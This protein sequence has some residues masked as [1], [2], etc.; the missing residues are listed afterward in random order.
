MSA[1]KSFI[2]VWNVVGEL[3]RPKNITRGSKAPRWQTKA[4]FHFTLHLKEIIFSY[5][6][7]RKGSGFVDASF[8][9]NFVSSVAFLRSTPVSRQISWSP[10]FSAMP[11]AP[12]LRQC[13]EFSPSP[14]F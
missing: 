10:T 11:L 13:F 14:F 2:I 6:W 12:K 7:T 8:R 5:S 3:H 1:N 4:A 9:G